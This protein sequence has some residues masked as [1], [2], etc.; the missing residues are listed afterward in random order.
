MQIQHAYAAAIQECLK[1]QRFSAAHLQNMS[2]NTK[3]NTLGCNKIVFS[4]AGESVLYVDKKTYAFYPGDV[5][6]ISAEQAH[7]FAE[8]KEKNVLEGMVF[9]VAPGFLQRNSSDR[10]DLSCCFR[11]MSSDG[12]HKLSLSEMERRQLLTYIQR[13][14]TNTEFGQDIH[15][16]GVFL[17]M[18]VYIN[19]L[20][21]THSLVTAPAGNS[22]TTASQ[23]GDIISYIDRHICEKL[24]TN[25]LAE[26][27][28]VSPSYLCKLFRSAT[29]TTVHKYITGK[30]VAM[31]KD[32]LANGMSVSTA[33]FSSGFNDY[34]NFIKI[35]TRAVGVSPKR[36]AMQQTK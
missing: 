22:A 9:L 35:F 2:K 28:F 18:M 16:N 30:R 3:T 4:V 27:F 25:N 36:Y 11:Q 23:I 10:T 26:H 13:L 33:C 19:Q 20:C 24:T 7:C 5:F 31:A 8:G 21:L 32:M 1:N 6:L 29:G 14:T 17:E 15:D 12:L 34:S